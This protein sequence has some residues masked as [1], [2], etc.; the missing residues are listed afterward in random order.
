MKRR[1]EVLSCFVRFFSLKPILL[2]QNWALRVLYGIGPY[3]SVRNMYTSTGILPFD[4]C[5]RFSSSLFL[6]K[7]VNGLA[8]VRTFP[9]QVVN[10]VRYIRSTGSSNFIL[11]IVF[12]SKFGL[13][14]G[15]LRLT[16]ILQ[17]LDLPQ[18]LLS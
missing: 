18:V 11:S 17:I 16:L 7:I 6:F 10:S 14:S 8:T 9:T 2:S 15:G 12:S 1:V 13:N 3:H 4:C 5:I